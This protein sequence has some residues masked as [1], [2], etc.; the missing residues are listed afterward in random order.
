MKQMGGNALK[1]E[2]K[3]WGDISFSLKNISSCP[4]EAEVSFE[5]FV[6]VV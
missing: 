3:G 4:L 5:T 2:K 1:A 6:Q